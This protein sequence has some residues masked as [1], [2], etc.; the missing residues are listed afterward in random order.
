MP[1]YLAEPSGRYVAGAK[2]FSRTAGA[3]AMLVGA[4]VLTGWLFDTHWL[5]SIYG[6]I[7]MKANAALSFL[8]AG[9]SLWTLSVDELRTSAR[10]AGQVCAA[11][12]ALTGLLTLSEH[13][14][15]WN[16]GIDQLL[17][18]EP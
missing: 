15:G 10:R 14:L 9:A 4:L 17:F 16:L 18:T 3:S 13:V 7:T 5:K 8:L 6:D 1:N 12:V 11:V 2:I